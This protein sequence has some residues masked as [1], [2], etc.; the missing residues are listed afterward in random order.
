MYNQKRLLFFR[1]TSFEFYAIFFLSH[2][3]PQIRR[4]IISTLKSD[5]QSYGHERYAAEPAWVPA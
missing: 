3:L 1:E 2:Q 5:D 4:V